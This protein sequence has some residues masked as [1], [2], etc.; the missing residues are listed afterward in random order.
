[1]VKVIADTQLE[2]RKLR[3]CE[4][5]RTGRCVNSPGPDQHERTVSM[6]TAYEM[7]TEW[8]ATRDRSEC[9][10]WPFSRQRQ[11][12][13]HLRRGGRLESA[14]RVAAA[15]DG[16]DPDGRVVRHTCDHPPCVNPDHLLLGTQLDNI[17]DRDVR[18]R[19]VT[20]SG[21]DHWAAKL[22]E[23]DV[24]SIRCDTRIQREIAAEF[25]VSRA[26]VSNIKRGAVWG[27]V[28]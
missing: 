10:E 18:G 13:G 19:Q 22:T 16:R 14:H 28:Q 4:N 8:V 6:S 25:G 3:V 2:Y 12:Y 1:M 5:G 7:L 24:R 21:E 15:L 17:R 9:W 20:P 27:H 11:G 26:V 23:D